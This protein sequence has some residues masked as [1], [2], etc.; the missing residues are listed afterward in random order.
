MAVNLVRNYTPEQAHH[1]LNSSFAQ[2]LADR[3]VVA[4]E[5][6]RQQD[7]A[8]TRGLPQEH[9]LPPR[10][11]RGVL[12]IPREGPAAPGRRSADIATRGA[13]TTSARA[14]RGSA[15]RRRVGPARSTPRGGGGRLVAR[16]EAHGARP[17][18]PVLPPERPGLRGAAAGP[19]EDPAAEV[20]QRSQPAVPPGRGG[21]ARGARHQDRRRAD[22]GRGPIPRSRARQRAW[23]N[24]PLRIHA[25]D[26]PNGR[27]TNGGRCVRAR[28]SDD[29][30]AWSGGSGFAPRRSLGSST[31]FS[32]CSVRS[33][34]WTRGR[35]RRRGGR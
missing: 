34:T 2:F 31:G 35:S 4:L 18:S 32:R 1:L 24:S 16:R 28:S 21:Q 6:S 17:G 19:H 5:R 33:D 3:G 7:L 10:G 14:W 26:A 20:R 22:D 29:S 23:R 25:A 8:T 27:S 11:L 30:V 13:A 9:G 15:G 12:G